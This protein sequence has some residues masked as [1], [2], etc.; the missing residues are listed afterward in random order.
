MNKF[1]NFFNSLLPLRPLFPY[2][3]TV[4]PTV[5]DDSLS[6]LETLGKVVKALNDTTS[7]VNTLEQAV[8]AFAVDLAQ[9]EN[10]SI[11]PVE[12]NYNSGSGAA[13]SASMTYA[14]I[15]S[16][17]GEGHTV[18]MHVTGSVYDTSIE[19]YSAALKA[20]TTSENVRVLF[21]DSPVYI[22]D[23]NTVI[24][25]AFINENNVPGV[26][27]RVIGGEDALIVHYDSDAGTADKTFAE[28][29]DAIEAEK[30]VILIADNQVINDLKWLTDVSTEN[31][32]T[33]TDLYFHTAYVVAAPNGFNLLAVN[34]DLDSSNTWEKSSYSFPNDSRVNA[35]IDNA[36]D[37]LDGSIKK[38][39]YNES[40]GNVVYYDG[41][42]S[43][44]VTGENIV[45]N[46]LSNPKIYVVLEGGVTTAGDTVYNQYVPLRYG[47]VNG[48]DIG[49]QFYRVFNGNIEIVTIPANSSVATKT[50][51]PI[52]LPATTNA[53][54]GDFLRLDSNKN[55][56]WDT[57]PSAESTSFGP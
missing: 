10:L 20:E 36:I 56:V 39:I 17:L 42:T 25:R 38:L 2:V 52:D 13:Y 28:I 3:Q 27:R 48:V 21:W 14:D 47:I 6:Y 37:G 51:T 19:F 33:I 7:N 26:L 45:L 49:V 16:A 15:V 50:S 23:G 44:P 12:I 53:S 41:E 31:V 55:A 24:Y 32:E 30:T 4:L 9:Y 40:T 1:N 18:I 43:T 8:R 5:F 46:F 11:T 34:Y 29:V 22:V 54:A 57:V 35:M